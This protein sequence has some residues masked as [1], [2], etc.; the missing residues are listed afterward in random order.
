MSKFI[1]PKLASAV[2]ALGMISISGAN[3]LVAQTVSTPIVGFSKVSAPSGTIVVVPS[4]VKAN[5]FQGAVT[6]SGQTFAVTGFAANQLAPSAHTDGRPNYPKA[7]VEITSG[8]FEGT[9]LDILS[10]TTSSVTVSGAPPELNGQSVSIAIRDH[11]TLDDLAQGQAGLVDYDSG[12]TLYNSDGTTSIR[13]YATGSW[14]ADD[15]STP[16]GNTIIY[17]GQ[18]ITLSSAPATLTLSGNVKQ[19][20][21]VIPLYSGGVVNLVGPGNPSGSDSLNAVN[22]ASALAPYDDG[23]NSFSSNG[24]MTIAETYYSDGAVILNSSYEPLPSP[25]Y[26]ASNSGFVVTVSSPKTWVLPKIVTP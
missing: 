7:Y 5:R 25:A 22:I 19:T 23:I 4:F 1:I 21:T 3:S 8:T 2:L 13:Y 9:V 26:V 18:G 24:L 20:K 16:A 17:P 14:V 10:N 15:Y 12:V 6:L 11:F